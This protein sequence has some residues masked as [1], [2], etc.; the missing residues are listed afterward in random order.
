[1]NNKG[2][3]L[4]E[5][6]AMLAVLAIL[7]GVAIPNITGILKNQKINSIKNDATTMVETAKSKVARN[8]LISNPS[9]QNKCIVF[10]LDYLNDND[11]IEH[12]P[13]GGKYND[14]E[15][16]V[17]IQKECNNGT[18][19]YKY[20]VRLIEENTGYAYGIIEPT[21]I[22]LVNKNDNQI[23]KKETSEGYKYGL[24]ANSPNNGSLVK[25]KSN[26]CPAGVISYYQRNKKYCTHDVN[27]A[28]PEHP[29]IYYGK[30]GNIYSTLDDCKKSGCDSC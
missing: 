1:M 6:L 5:L 2:F 18:C 25:N 28:D 22:T 8:E 26:K 23:I 29:N 4:V 20:Y 7:M 9:E 13:N 14:Y 17:I 10:S 19:E 21:D 12:G 24:V 27:H 16:F 15:S 30:D 3:T 11:N